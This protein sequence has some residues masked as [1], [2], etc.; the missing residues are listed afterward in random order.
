MKYKQHKPG[1]DKRLTSLPSVPSI[2]VSNVWEFVKSLKYMWKS[3]LPY[4]IMVSLQTNVQ[5]V[6]EGLGCNG[7]SSSFL[8]SSKFHT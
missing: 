7:N 3:A 1:V 8:F 4:T 2:F 5:A 6:A